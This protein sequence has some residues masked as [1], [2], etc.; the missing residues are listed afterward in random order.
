MIEK[1][2]KEQYD[3]IVYLQDEFFPASVGTRGSRETS[4]H[5]AY[6]FFQEKFNGV[7]DKVTEGGNRFVALLNP[8]TRN[9]VF[10]K[11]VELEKKYFWTIE[12]NNLIYSFNKI[13]D[14]DEA[15]YFDTDDPSPLTASQIKNKFG[16]TFNLKEFNKEEVE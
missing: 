8:E 10:D 3:Y 2:T 15:I 13:S 14:E 5:D 12:A 6:G 1:F 4:L 16:E 11:F 9:L 7:G